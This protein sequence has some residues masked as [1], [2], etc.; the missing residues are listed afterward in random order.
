MCDDL[1]VWV[2]LF[3]LMYELFLVVSE[4]ECKLCEWNFFVLLLCLL[5]GIVSLLYILMCYN[6]I[7]LVVLVWCL[8]GWMLFFIVLFYLSVLVFVVLIKYEIFVNFVGWLFVELL[9]WVM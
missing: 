6:M 2:E 8:V 7:M 4:D 3:V 5:F 1:F 9:V